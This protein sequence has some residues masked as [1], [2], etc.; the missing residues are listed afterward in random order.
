MTAASL[1]SSALSHPLPNQSLPA[2]AVSAQAAA[3]ST[4]SQAPQD[5]VKGFAVAPLIDTK[6][7][8]SSDSLVESYTRVGERT[9]IKR[10]VIGR[11]CSI[12]KNVKLTGLVVMDGVRI[13]DK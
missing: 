4:S 9:T 6:S 7:Q 13:G 12:G 2:P 3:D 11:G 5:A 10:S 1:P 8:I